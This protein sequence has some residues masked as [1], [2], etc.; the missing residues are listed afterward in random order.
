MYFTKAPL[1]SYK[2]L[3]RVTRAPN[4]HKKI[5]NSSIQI[6]TIEIFLRT[7]FLWEKKG[8]TLDH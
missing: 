8:T 3:F 5:V 6:F 1:T 2:D 4:K 7:N